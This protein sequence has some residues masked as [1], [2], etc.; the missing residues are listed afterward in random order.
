MHSERG[1]HVR[2]L[3]AEVL[4]MALYVAISLLAAVLTAVPDAHGSL[5]LLWGIALGLAL[6][7]SFAFRLSARFFGGGRLSSEDLSATGAQ[8]TGAIAVALLATLAVVA[9]PAPHESEAVVYALGGFLGLV[10][11]GVGRCAGGS[12]LR[13]GAYGAVVLAGALIVIVVKSVISGH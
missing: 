10:G 5:P 11:V 9:A 8:L 13:S 2:E 4:T 6:T 1:A 3:L 12:W 7:H